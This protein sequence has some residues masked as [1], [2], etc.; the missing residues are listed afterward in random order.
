ME[1]DRSNPNFDRMAEDMP[2]AR[3]SSDSL[4]EAIQSKFYTFLEE[5]EDGTAERDSSS[6]AP[7]EGEGKPYVALVMQMGVNDTSTLVVNFQHLQAFDSDAANAIKLNYYRFEP[8]L[9]KAVQEFAVRHVGQ[10]AAMHEGKPKEYYVS[11]F[12]LPDVPC[13]LRDLRTSKLG[14]LVS[15][16]GTITRTS[17]VRPEL[18]YGTFRCMDCGNKAT[19]VEQQFQ[20]TQPTLCKNATCTNRERWQLIREE[21]IFVDWQRVR[22]QENSDEVPPGCLP[23]TLEVV[24]RNEMVEKCRA[25]DKSVLTGTLVVVPDL[26]AFTRAGDRTEKIPGQ[27]EGAGRRGGGGVGPPGG[28]TGLKA[29]GPRDLSYRLCFLA[30]TVQAADSRSF[31]QINIRGDEDVAAQEVLEEFTPEQQAEVLNL[32]KQ[33]GLYQLLVNSVAP[34]VYGH[35]DI[36]RAILL[37]LFGGLHKVTPEGIQ[38]RGDI[39]V[40]IVGDPSCAKSQFLKYVAGFLPRA[41]YTSGKSSSA[42]GLTASV[43]READTGEFCIEAGALMLADNGICCIDEFDKMDVKDQVAIHEAMEQQTISIAK[44][45]IQAT[46]NARTSILAAANPVY[47]RYDK[48]KPLKFNVNLPP[49]I[50]SRFDLLHVMVDEVD[51]VGDF[52]IAK[53]I[54]SLHQHKAATE[55]GLSKEQLQRYIRYAR[56]IKPQFSPAAREQLVRAYVGMRHDD[57]QPGSQSSYRITVRQLEGLVRL[58]EALAR[59]HC[60][61]EIKPARVEEARRLLSSSIISVETGPVEVEDLDFFMEGDDGEGDVGADGDDDSPVD[62]NNNNN[63]NND[64]DHGGDGPGGARGGDGNTGEDEDEDADDGDD[65][66]DGDAPTGRRQRK[67]KGKGKQ[68]AP[69]ASKSKRGQASAEQSGSEGGSPSAPASKRGKRRGTPTDDKSPVMPTSSEGRTRQG[70]GAESSKKGREEEVSAGASSGKAKKGKSSSSREEAPEG[71]PETAGKEGAAERAAA[72]PSR[73]A[74][75][76]V[77]FRKFQ[78]V[79]NALVIKLRQVEDH[80]PEGETAGM[81]QQELV[82][83]YVEE[84]HKREAFTNDADLKNEIKL[85]RSIIQ[86]MIKENNL[87]IVSDPEELAAADAAFAVAQANASARGAGEAERKALVEARRRKRMAYDQRVLTPHPNFVLE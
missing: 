9:R 73:P 47:G 22:M 75:V 57:A 74:P 7:V 10:D 36:K 44:A 60:E 37:M 71:E 40:C 48:T 1:E 83:W 25:G 59:L 23:R 72:E 45:G 70:A 16:S 79:Q 50:L 80:A 86:H 26:A 68:G 14:A 13:K 82:E 35:A 69:A 53:H 55:E 63:D 6:H 58:S 56:T 17:E 20:Y 29:L 12:N 31:G 65:D 5:F 54:V 62:D 51:E 34:S 33:R 49:A 2:Q 42:A 67:G 52:N 8:W 64:D 78:R 76:Q 87:T 85:V 11:F 66:D 43:V 38:L 61:A 39:N 27:A 77:D 30:T 24:L 18:L 21:S 19:N 3:G 41:V 46:L 32:S 4:N 84:Q 81:T 15:V 28:V